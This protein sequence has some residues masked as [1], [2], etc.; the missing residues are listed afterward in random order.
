MTNKEL[1]T[2][3]LNLIRCDDVQT[4]VLIN[5]VIRLLDEPEPVKAAAPKKATPQKKGGPKRKPFDIGKAKACRD[6][7]WSLDKIADEM[8]VS[9]PTV[10]KHLAD[11]GY[12]GKE[13]VNEP[14]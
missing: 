1:I 9:A 2:E 13:A 6:A 14:N 10:K 7:G 4:A 3:L 11:A 12:F 5:A 8:G